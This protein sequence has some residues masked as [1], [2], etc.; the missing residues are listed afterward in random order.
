MAICVMSRRRK[1]D[2]VAVFRELCVILPQR[3]VKRIVLDFEDATWRAVRIIFP[4]VQLKGCAFHFTQAIWR[5][6]QEGG[7]QVAYI[8]DD[9]TF[10][11]LRKIMA[12]C[13]LPAQ[14]ILPIFQRLQQEAT[15]TPLT[16]LLQYVSRTWINSVVW[17]PECWSVYYQSVRTN[18]DLEGW[19]NRLNSRGRAGMN[20]YMLVKLLHKESSKIPV[21]VRLVSEG[22]LQ[23]HQKKAFANM[24]RIIFAYWEE[25][26]NGNRSALQLL[27]ACSRLYG[28]IVKV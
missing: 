17:P 3:Q 8:N 16:K 4:T 5:H 21:Q 22:K 1:K 26:N 9:G 10:K 12:L 27:R 2:Y 20:L 23:R 13:F 15:T 18:N 14:H 6:I 19:H 25:Y 11:F 24:R 7:L 28:P